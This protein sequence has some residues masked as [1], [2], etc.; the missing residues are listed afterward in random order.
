MEK[1]LLEDGKCNSILA[2]VLRL[3]NQ[4]LVQAIFICLHV[5]VYMCFAVIIM[6]LLQPPIIP[7]S[8]TGGVL[9]ESG[10]LPTKQQLVTALT[11]YIDV[12]LKDWTTHTLS[13]M[14]ELCTHN[15]RQFLELKV[16]NVSRYIELTKVH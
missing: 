13:D 15:H 16:C 12:S 5:F 2:P 11:H 1:E 10:V 8:T 6:N 9:L 14:T 4:L 7:M 3:T